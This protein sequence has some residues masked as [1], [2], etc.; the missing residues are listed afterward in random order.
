MYKWLLGEF[1]EAIHLLT[2]IPEVCKKCFDKSMA[3]AD[4]MSIKNLNV[5]VM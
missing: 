5:S 1:D 4:A 2:E 3:L